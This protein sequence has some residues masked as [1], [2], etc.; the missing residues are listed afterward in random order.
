MTRTTRQCA[1][2]ALAVPAVAVPQ[3]SSLAILW[4]LVLL[5]QKEV[6]SVIHHL[7]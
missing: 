3:S 1:G 5:Y 6:P 2:E 4:V 7:P